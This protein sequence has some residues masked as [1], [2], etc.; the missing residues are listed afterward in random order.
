MTVDSISNEYWGCR[1]GYFGSVF[2][3]IADSYSIFKEYHSKYYENM[4]I[5]GGI[6][7]CFNCNEISLTEPDLD[8]NIAY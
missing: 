5:Y 1:F 7:Y 4:S 6:L 2:A 3:L 8:Y